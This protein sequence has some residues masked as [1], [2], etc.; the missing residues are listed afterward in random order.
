M[1]EV[2][3]ENVAQ[4]AEH[5]IQRMICDGNYC[6]KQSNALLLKQLFLV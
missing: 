3:L 1:H 5:S 2:K 4:A 6:L